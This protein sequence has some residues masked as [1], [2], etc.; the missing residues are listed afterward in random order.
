MFGH[1]TSCG[2][3]INTVHVREARGKKI[4]RIALAPCNHRAVLF[5]YNVPTVGA[6]DNGCPASLEASVAEDLIAAFFFAGLLL[7][8]L[9]LFLF[10][11]DDLNQLNKPIVQVL[12]WQR[13][14]FLMMSWSEALAQKM[15]QNSIAST[16]LFQRTP[17]F[18][19]ESR[20][21]QLNF[22]VSI[23]EF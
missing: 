23:S 10:F 18:L 1:T 4:G 13:S 22:V 15:R 19:Q 9:S 16:S 14:V 7:F 17:N 5:S 11:E 2:E 6:G 20:S 3:E 21:W 12:M 8:A